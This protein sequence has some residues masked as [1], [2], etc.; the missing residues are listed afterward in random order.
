MHQWLNMH[1][2]I[3]AGHHSSLDVKSGSYI[4]ETVWIL[5]GISYGSF[6]LSLLD[7]NPTVLYIQFY[8]WFIVICSVL[9]LSH[10]MKQ[11]FFFSVLVKVMVQFSW[12]VCTAT[13]PISSISSPVS[14]AQPSVEPAAMLM[15]WQ[16]P[17]VSSLFITFWMSVQQNLCGS[18]TLIMQNDA[19]LTWT[20]SVSYISCR[21]F[22]SFWHTIW[23][24]GSVGGRTVSLSGESGGVLQW[25]VG[26]RL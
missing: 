17:A 20:M 21:L 24:E 18:W 4:V 23:A 19:H 22:S 9:L 6:P 26:D 8:T 10:F 15:M 16:L 11:L 1:I 7:V 5:L 13:L 14:T 25:T 2:T 3:A 12:T